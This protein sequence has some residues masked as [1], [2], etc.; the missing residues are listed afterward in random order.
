M[1]LNLRKKSFEIFNGLFDFGSGSIRNGFYPIQQGGMSAP[2]VNIVRTQTG[3]DMT[4]KRAMEI[5]AVWACVWLIAGTIASMPFCLKRRPTVGAKYGLDDSLNPLYGVLS[6]KPNAAMDAITYW[7]FMEASKLLWGN[8]YSLIDRSAGQVSVLET[9]LPQFMV[10]YRMNDSGEIRYKYFP[11]GLTNLP[12]ADYSADQIFHVR[13]HSLDGMI[14]L[15]RVEFGRQSMGIARATD[16]TTAE[17]FKN[18]MRSNG[19]LYV[20][21]TLTEKQREQIHEDLARWKMSGD[22]ANSFMVL[23]AGMKFNALSLPPQDAELLESRKF[24]VQDICRWFN[25]PPIL[26]G[27]TGTSTWGTGIEQLFGGFKALC[28]RPEIREIEMAVQTQLVTV[29]DRSMVFLAI[30][31]EDF[32][33]MD[34]TARSAQESTDVQNGIKT[35]NEVRADRGLAP[36][37]GADALTCQVNLTPLDKL[38]TQ[39]PAMNPQPFGQKSDEDPMESPAARLVRERKLQLI[40]GAKP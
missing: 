9:L 13:G 20:D 29:K 12:F 21:K 14:G 35:R 26:I 10:P 1:K 17:V 4:P 37:D 34:S 39:P 19:F 32:N 31:L 18:G 3:D 5:G 7:K 36:I 33:A 2:P 6:L 38:G 40:S 25:V 23:E 16:M 24:E 27:D 30:D 15:S 22:K 28:L 11:G 8:A